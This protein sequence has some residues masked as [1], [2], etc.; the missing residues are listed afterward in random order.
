V[1]VDDQFVC[2]AIP[3]SRQTK[4]QRQAITKSRTA[5]IDGADLVIKQTRKR[6]ELREFEGNPILSPELDPL[7]KQPSFSAADQDEFLDFFKSDAK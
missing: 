7:R 3:H 6:A 4:E 5:R 2:D 1:F